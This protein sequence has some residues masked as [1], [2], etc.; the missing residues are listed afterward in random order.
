MAA[1]GVLEALTGKRAELA[2][3]REA[4]AAELATL[5]RAL[6]HLD[7]T[8]HL[9]RADRERNGS[10]RPDT[11]AL[12]RPFLL[13]GVRPGQ[14]ARLALDVLRTATA[15]MTAQDI[16][17]QLC[18]QRSVEADAA[19]I[20]RLSNALIMALRQYERRGLVTEVGRTA[21]RAV[22]WRLAE[23]QPTAT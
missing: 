8:I 9:F 5:D 3:Q 7:G 22:L 17:R 6:E 21:L 2:L 4:V 13:P 20:G 15:P 23:D 18:E 1:D 14:T 12:Q 16:A 19:V 11:N 10:K